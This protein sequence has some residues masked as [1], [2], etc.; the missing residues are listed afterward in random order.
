MVKDAR[1]AL[2]NVGPHP[3]RAVLA[4]Q[5]LVGTSLDEESID[6][7]AEL[8]VQECEPLSDSLASSWYRRTMAPRIIR[9]VLM[10]LVDQE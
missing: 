1:L 3:A 5:A 10:Q 9:R 6:R 7:A 2:G 4:E 8:A